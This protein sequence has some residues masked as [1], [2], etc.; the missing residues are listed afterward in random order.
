M[1]NKINILIIDDLH[2]VFFQYINR[3]DINLNYQP[4]ISA[5]DVANS[6]KEIEILILR[7]KVRVDEK[8]CKNANKLKLVIRAGSG[9]DN[10]DI[11]WLDKKRIRVINTPEANR[12]SVAEQ[13]AGM[14]L[15]LMSNI[16]KGNSEVKSNIWNREDNRG[17]ELFGKTI[18]IIG[19]GNTGSEFAKVISG[20]GVNIFAYDKYKSG[21]SNNYVQ[22]VEMDSIFNQSDIVSL[23]IPLTIETRYLVNE[24]YISKFKKSIRLLNTSR[25]EIVKTS[26]IINAIEVGKIKGFASDVLENEKINSLN[27]NEKTEFLKL[28]SFKNVIITPHI[29]GWTKE[30]YKKISEAIAQKINNY[31]KMTVNDSIEMNNKFNKIAIRK[32]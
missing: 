30:S 32:Y 13:A 24:D 14:L 22:E 25:G 19:F 18:G 3:S 15:A 2:P 16:V 11:E 17:E 12:V 21:F 20:F 1:S 8:L 5:V 7:S 31:S 4:E 29:A 6:L 23:H 27:K 28:C 10:I 9:M 26:D